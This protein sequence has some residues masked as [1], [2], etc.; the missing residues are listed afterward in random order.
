MALIAPGA[1]L[2]LLHA[3]CS[4]YNGAPL[5]GSS[6]WSV[7][8]LAFAPVGFA[9]ALSYAE[10]SKALSRGCIV[11]LFREQAF[12]I[13]PRPIAFGRIAKFMT[14][15]ASH[16]YYWVYPD[17]WS[18]C[19]HPQWV[20]LIKFFSQHLQWIDQQ[21]P[22]HEISSAWAL[23]LAWPYIAFRGVTGTTGSTCSSI[24]CRSPPCWSSR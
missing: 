20:S 17:A 1:F 24:S 8:W 3:T 5:A 23:L 9:T 12:S 6:M 18:A 13:T 15:W 10:L 16:L 11:Y 7:S 4:P 22:L 21:S 2:W 14:G 19:S